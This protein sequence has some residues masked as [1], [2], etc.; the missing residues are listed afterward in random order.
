MQISHI[1]NWNNL[2]WGKIRERVCELQKH[3]YQAAKEC[4]LYKTFKLQQH[5]LQSSDAKIIAIQEI[6]NYILEY[7]SSYTNQTYYLNNSDKFIIY[8]SLFNNCIDNTNL[9]III[10]KVKEYIRYMCLEPEWKA[11]FKNINTKQSNDL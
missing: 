6:S 11:K 3:I 9:K 4:N 2:P 1:T 7:Y 10:E 8:Q 5:F